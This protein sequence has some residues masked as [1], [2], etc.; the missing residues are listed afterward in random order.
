MHLTAAFQ[1]LLPF[2]L[3]GSAKTPLA[4]PIIVPSVLSVQRYP[5]SWHVWPSALED[6]LLCRKIASISKGKMG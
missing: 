1:P 2:S 4:V 6:K 5:N 3:L